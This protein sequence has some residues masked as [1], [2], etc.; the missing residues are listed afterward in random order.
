MELIYSVAQHEHKAIVEN[1]DDKEAGV[2]GEEYRQHDFNQYGKPHLY[3]YWHAC[4][5]WIYPG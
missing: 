3:I 4:V 5:L 2:S 1:R